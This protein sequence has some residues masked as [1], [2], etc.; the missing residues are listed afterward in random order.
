MDKRFAFLLAA[1]VVFG[2][3]VGVGLGA[4][5]AQGRGSSTPMAAAQGAVAAKST[6]SAAAAGNQAPAGTEATT[7]FGSIQSVADKTFT[8]NGQSGIVSV[9]VS[10][11]TKI[12]K[13]VSA[14]KDQIKVGETISASGREGE[15]G[16]LTADVVE[17]GAIQE[18]GIPGRVMIQR[19]A[20]EAGSTPQSGSAPVRMQRV[21]GTVES[22][23]QNE[24]TVKT[25]AGSKTITI[26]DGATIRR[27]EAGSM[28]DLK[29]GANV[30]VS[31]KPDSAGTI[32]AQQIRL[33]DGLTVPGRRQQ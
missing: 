13:T 3:T 26:G 4:W 6:P 25:D 9:S 29:V 10:E 7:V 15:G 21:A 14:S 11:E 27:T 19:P 2:L 33:A 30:I 18:A 16:K 1:V 31:G 5:Q 12:I 22:I 8:L 28:D 20:G 23:D 17:I 24:V 32:E